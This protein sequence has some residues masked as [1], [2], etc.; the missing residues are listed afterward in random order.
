MAFI[1]PSGGTNGRTGSNKEVNT[2]QQ[3]STGAKLDSD[4]S[5]RLQP[6]PTLP[7]QTVFD[8][9]LVEDFLAGDYCLNGVK[10]DSSSW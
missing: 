8:P 9:K 6:P 3:G 7:P 2:E 1:T 5:P 10:L 4:T